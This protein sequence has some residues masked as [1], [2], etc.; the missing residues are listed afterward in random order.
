M[1]GTEYANTARAFMSTP[2]AVKHAENFL[3]HPPAGFPVKKLSTVRAGL[4]ILRRAEIETQRYGFSRSG[5][6]RGI[7]SA[8]IAMSEVLP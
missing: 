3:A 1:S 4:R 8:L 2:D 5:V 7:A 6:S